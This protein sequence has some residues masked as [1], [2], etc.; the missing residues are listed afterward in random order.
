MQLSKSNKTGSS[1][2]QVTSLFLLVLLLIGAGDD[3]A[4]FN[5]L[6]HR[7]M[8][9]CGCKQVLLECNHVGCQYSD[10]MRAELVASIDRGNNDSLVQQDFIQKYGPAV[11]L[12]P[13]TTGFNKVAWVM[14]YAALV[15]G[16]GIVC[17]IV[18]GWNKRPPNGGGSLPPDGNGN[19]SPSSNELDK[20]RKQAR[21]ETEL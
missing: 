6:G 20:F 21:Q 4:R 5:S 12:A 11:L 13:T 3:S 14:P 15:F 8:C 1:A 19:G 2:T 7:L 18:W 9:M 17:M 16:I 10:A